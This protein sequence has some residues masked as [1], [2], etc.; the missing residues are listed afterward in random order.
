[1]RRPAP[2]RPRTGALVFFLALCLILSAALCAPGAALAQVDR[3]AGRDTARAVCAECH[4]VE[5]EQPAVAASPAPDFAEIAARPEIDAAA[6]RAFL[7]APHPSM[8]NLH[9]L[10]DEADRDD[11]AAYILS[12]SGSD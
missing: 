11:V 6:I 7:D 4:R 3:A 12:L 5:P 8:P 2:A 10:L 1:M 9:L